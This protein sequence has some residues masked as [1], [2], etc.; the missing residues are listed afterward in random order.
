MNQQSN[1]ESRAGSRWTPQED[2][3]LGTMPDEQLAARLGRPL[4]GVLTRRHDLDIPKFAPKV[5]AWTL[6]ENALLGTMPDKKLARRLKRSYDAVAVRRLKKGIPHCNP[7]R[8]P[9]RPEDDKVLGTRPDEQI[10]MLLKRSIIAI[11]NRRKKT[12]HP[13]LA[14]ERGTAL[15]FVGRQTSWHQVRSRNRTHTWPHIGFGPS[16][17]AQIGH[18]ARSIKTGVEET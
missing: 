18:P 6:E 5:R 2:A 9:W 11:Q 3:L 13:R 7:K 16:E 14:R 8:K 1:I 12:W 17:A 4:S 15:D 10:S